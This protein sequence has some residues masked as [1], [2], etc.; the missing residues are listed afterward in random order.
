MNE[1]DFLDKLTELTEWEY[2]KIGPNGCESVVKKKGR[3]SIEEIEWDENEEEMIGEEV[4]V[5]DN[6]TLPPK[7]VKL[8]PHVELCPDCGKLCENRIVESRMN[9]KPVVHWRTKCSVCKNYKDP[10]TGKFDMNDNIKMQSTFRSYCLKK[11]GD[12]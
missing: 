8:K 2:P 10:F 9:H 4:V 3:R 7:I 11:Q 5:S 1:K 6:D 12:K